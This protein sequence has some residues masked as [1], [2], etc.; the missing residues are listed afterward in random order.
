M[1]GEDHPRVRLSTALGDMI[2]AVEQVR[3]PAT[4]TYF[5]RDVASG[6]YDGTSFYRVVT[7]ANQDPEQSVPIEIVQGGVRQ[8]AEPTCPSLE[9]ESTLR[10][11]L[12]HRRGSISLSRFAPGAVYHGF[13]LCRRDEPELDHGG[14]RQPDG[15]GFA[16]FGEIVEGFDVLDRIF[17][18]AEAREALRDEI[19]IYRA[20]LL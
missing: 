1:S 2:I 13:F 17:A 16:A 5:L 9:H 4:G 19:A 14:A 20:V 8:P 15:L 12:R 11:G 6:R 10:T 18:R 3:A 7:L